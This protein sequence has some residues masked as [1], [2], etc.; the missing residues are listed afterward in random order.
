MNNIVV[1]D[2]DIKK[3]HKDELDGVAKMEEYINAYGAMN[4]L[5]V[6]TPSGGTHYC[7]RYDGNDEDVRYIM[8]HSLFT[9]S[10]LGGYS[11][12]I[13]SDGG[14]ATIPPSSIDGKSYTVINDSPI[15]KLS[16]IHI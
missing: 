3:E 6:R 16:L 1:V 12:D 9:R 4:T 7:F 2:V 5:T 10:G 15:T 13:R 8:K 14:L 11:I